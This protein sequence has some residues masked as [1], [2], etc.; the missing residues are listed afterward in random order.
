MNEFENLEFFAIRNREGQWFHRK[1]YSGYGETWREDVLE[2]RIYNKI[3]HARAQVT[4]FA[5]RWPSFG[6]P[7]I[8]VFKIGETAVINEEERIKKREEKTE[9]RAG[10]HRLKT[11][12]EKLAEAKQE[13]EEV[14]DHSGINLRK[15][16]YDD[17]V[18]YHSGLNMKRR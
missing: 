15:R 13:Y 8:V 1:G 18:Q 4:Y 10:I 16:K 5:R 7:E 17:E 2:A 9:K 3:G 6:I 14:Q 12:R 11:A